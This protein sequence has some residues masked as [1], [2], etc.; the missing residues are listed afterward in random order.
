[1]ARLDRGEVPAVQ[2][3]DDF[4]SGALGQRDDARVGAAEWKV[5][6]GLDQLCHPLKVL[7]SGRLDIER[8]K[9]AKE[10]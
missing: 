2:R 8:L 3:D 1:M 6:V 7:D 5:T 9:G 4:G 10:R